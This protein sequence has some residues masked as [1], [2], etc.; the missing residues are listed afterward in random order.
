MVGAL[1]GIAGL[2][3]GLRVN[4]GTAWFATF[5]IGAPAA[6]VGFALGAVT[7]AIREDM[8]QRTA[9]RRRQARS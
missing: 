3:I 2:V 6:V 5:E 7:G 9:R 8:Q 4:P 1:G